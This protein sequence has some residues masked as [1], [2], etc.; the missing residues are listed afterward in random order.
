MLTATEAK[1]LATEAAKTIDPSVEPMIRNAAEK[2]RT[3]VRCHTV[4]NP[5]L[6]AALL[7][8][9]GY[10]VTINYHTAYQHTGHR[11]LTDPATLTIS[12]KNPTK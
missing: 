12:W 1:A 7:T 6:T 10:S 11:D 3:S 4:Q 8:S 2:G 5:Q 9:N